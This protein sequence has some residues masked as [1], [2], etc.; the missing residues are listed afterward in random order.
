[1]PGRP[2]AA[3]SWLGPSAL[4]VPVKAFGQAKIRLAG[5]LSP[6]QRA[7][8]A[9]N[10]ATGVVAAAGDLAVAVVCDD[11]EVARWARDLGALVIWEP[12]RG[13][14][15][16]V[17]EGVD[18]LAAAGVEHVVVAHADL[19]L[20][21]DLGWIARFPGVTLI[22]DRH[23]EGTNVIGIPA[24]QFVYVRL[25]SRLVCPPSRRSAAAGPPGT[26]RSRFAAGLGCGRARRSAT[27]HR[28]TEPS[29]EP[30][31]PQRGL[32]GR[33]PS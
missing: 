30:P 16:A 20:A 11:R 3:P 13:L 2:N 4:L 29:A 18:R 21:S 33:R 12:G 15:G 7:E 6:G 26:H 31:I 23:H 1:M 19:P 10:L 25:R 28:M 9:R 17:Q 22:P 14:N 32:G 8:L 27:C 5:A 24:A